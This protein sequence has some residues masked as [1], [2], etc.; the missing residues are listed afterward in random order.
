MRASFEQ[1]REKLNSLMATDYK[2][3]DLGRNSELF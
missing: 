3:L 2:N 1:S